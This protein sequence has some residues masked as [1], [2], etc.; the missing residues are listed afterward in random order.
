MAA[1]VLRGLCSIVELSRLKADWLSRSR[2]AH[3]RVLMFSLERVMENNRNFIL[4]VALSFAVVIAW[5][6]LFWK[7][8]ELA[9]KEQQIE[10]AKNS[11]KPAQSE[12]AAPGGQ[13]A[14]SQ[15][16]PAVSAQPAL[17]A[18]FATREA[19]IAASPRVSIESPALQGS[20]NLKGARIDDVILRNYKETVKPDSANVVLLSPSGSPHPYFT[21]TGWW[22]SEP[23]VTLPGEDTLWQQEGTGPLTSSHPVVLRYDNDSGLI[24]RRTISVD[25]HFMF[26]IT[27][28]VENKSGKPVTLRPWGQ[29]AELTEPQTLGYSVLHEGMIGVFGSS[30]LKELTYAAAVKNFDPATNNAKD[31]YSASKGG[32]IGFTSQYWAAV[33]IPNQSKPFDG[34]MFGNEQ[35]HFYANYLQEPVTVAPGGKESITNRLFA[36]AKEVKLL[37]K[38]RSDLSIERFNKLVDWGWFFFLTEPMFYLMDFLYQLVGNFGVAILLTTVVVKAAF[39]PLAN[40]SFES[41]SKMKKLQPEMK[42]IQERFKDDKGRQQEALMKLY[43]DEKVNPM[44][45]CLPIFIQIPV[46]FSLYKVLLVAIEMRHAPFIGWIKDLSAPDPTSVFNLFG[47]IPWAPP[48]FLMLG[49]LPLAMGISMWVQMRLNPVP[50]DPIQQQVF[51]WMPV[52]FT[53]MLARFPAGLVLYWTWNNILSFSQQALIMKRQGVEIDILHNVGIKKV[54]GHVQQVRSRM[55]NNGS[56]RTP[57]E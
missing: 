29:V 21:Y 39:F 12:T 17:A 48:Q 5:D 13:P 9:R 30:G 42:K 25:A 52:I 55:K 54:H 28:E 37:E 7:P 46:F 14:V 20:I 24:F 23:G 11:Q 1:R 16:T 41:M 38:Y 49:I 43:K 22:T 33:L 15:G 45:G 44:A 40:K 32:W 57:A 31:T 36:G 27:D 8:A 56:S 19:A 6:L 34:M 10:A 3:S 53:F 2:G 35:K 51:T 47:L 4:A 26:T 18:A 50:A